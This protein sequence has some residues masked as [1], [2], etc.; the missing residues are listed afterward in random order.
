MRSGKG[1]DFLML[2]VVQMVGLSAAD[3]VAVANCI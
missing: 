3:S 2:I 1:I